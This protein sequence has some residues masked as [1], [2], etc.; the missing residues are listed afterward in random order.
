MAAVVEDVEIDLSRRHGID[1]HVPIAGDR[2]AGNRSHVTQELAARQRTV[3][4][5]CVSGWLGG[6]QPHRA[7]QSQ[8]DS[9]KGGYFQGCFHSSFLSLSRFTFIFVI[10]V[11]LRVGMRGPFC[12]SDLSLLNFSIMPEGR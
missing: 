1:V 7:E 9:C 10:V 11:Q 6:G 2:G 12:L 4:S 5:L 8:R 3:L